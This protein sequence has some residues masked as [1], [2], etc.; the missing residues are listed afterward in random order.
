MN[1][2]LSKNKFLT[3]K[4]FFIGISFTI[5]ATLINNQPAN[6]QTYEC[7][8]VN[9]PFKFSLVPVSLD[10]CG[11]FVRLDANGSSIS[12]GMWGNLTI[13][14]ARSG[15]MYKLVNDSWK[16]LG[17]ITDIPLSDQCQDGNTDACRKWGKNLD[18]LLQRCRNG[19]KLTG[20]CNSN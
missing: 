18:I 17:V 1:I 16:Y 4:L 13:A 11:T 6:G 9:S 7:K 19:E 20:L 3:M 5:A 14:V 2:N 15:E 10:V 8:P 12:T